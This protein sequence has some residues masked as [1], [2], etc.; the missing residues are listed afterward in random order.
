[1]INITNRIDELNGI[2]ASGNCVS[3]DL[4]EYSRQIK[5][6]RTILEWLNYQC[7]ALSQATYDNETKEL[8][9]K[10]KNTTKQHFRIVRFELETSDLTKIPI[11]V[12]NWKPNETKAISFFHDFNNDIGYKTR[13]TMKLSIDV[14]SVEYDLYDKNALHNTGNDNDDQFV[15]PGE[16]SRAQSFLTIIRIFYK[17][18]PDY[19]LKA[20]ARKLEGLIISIYDRVALKSELNS[21]ISKLEEIYL[22]GICKSLD[23][24]TDVVNKGTV[25]SNANDLKMVTTKALNMAVKSTTKLK[26]ELYSGSFVESAVDVTAIEDLMKRDGLL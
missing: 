11:S 7:S 20:K 23:N 14:H 4:N 1:M 22:P 25:G 15:T 12:N 16:Y 24:Y 2:I 18:V 9:M 21:K 6:M 3:S 13:K 8:S 17:T 19:D 5:E 26:D 10:M